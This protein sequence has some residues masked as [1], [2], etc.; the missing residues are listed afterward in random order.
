[1]VK[2]KSTSR[3]K[4]DS[5]LLLPSSETEAGLNWLNSLGEAEFRDRVLLELFRKMQAEGSLEGFENIHGRNDKGIDY[6]ITFK[7]AFGPSLI[8]LQ[9]KSKPMTRSESSGSLSAIRIRQECEAALLHDFHFQGR[10]V[11]IDSIEIWTSASSQK[12]PRRS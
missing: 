3:T 1:M 10:S 12:T 8:G 9:I 7:S 11:R 2:K 6:I 5:P 4:D